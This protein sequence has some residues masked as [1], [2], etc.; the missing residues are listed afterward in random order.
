M[1]SLGVP[2]GLPLV[3][4]FTSSGEPLPN[5]LGAGGSIPP[6]QGNSLGAEAPWFEALDRDRSGTLSAAELAQGGLCDPDD[7]G[8][9]EALADSIDNN[10]S[11]DIDFNEFFAWVTR[12]TD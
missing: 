8:A 11:G 1:R 2:N 7:P 12:G 10:G 3:Y 9:C 5:A 6:L 4:E